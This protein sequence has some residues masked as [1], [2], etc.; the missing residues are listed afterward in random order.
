MGRRE[1]ERERKR[2]KL[3]LPRV[4]YLLDNSLAT[5]KTE[6]ASERVQ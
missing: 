6:A 1:D 5:D 3:A 4:N 2:K